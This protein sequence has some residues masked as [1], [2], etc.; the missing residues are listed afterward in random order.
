MPRTIPSGKGAVGR[1]DCPREGCPMKN[2]AM[3]G[4]APSFAVREARFQFAST[5]ERKE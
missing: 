1:V 3:L 5:V 2:S 4:A